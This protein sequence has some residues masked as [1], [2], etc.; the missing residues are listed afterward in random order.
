MNGTCA[1]P[2][3]KELYHSFQ[4]PPEFLNYLFGAAR[5]SH[6]KKNVP[7]FSPTRYKGLGPPLLRHHRKTLVIIGHHFENCKVFF[8]PKKNWGERD[9][10]GISPQNLKAGGGKSPQNHPRIWSL[11]GNSS[12]HF[13]NAT[14]FDKNK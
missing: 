14:K 1:C 10:G 3:S 9:S 12:H 13:R 4:M 6:L 2:Q 11:G 5:T 8:P 7:F